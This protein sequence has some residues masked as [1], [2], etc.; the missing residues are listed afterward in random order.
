MYDNNVINIMYKNLLIFC[1]IKK[2][3]RLEILDIT[4]VYTK[5]LI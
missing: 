3:E 1:M 4:S 2:F 5:K